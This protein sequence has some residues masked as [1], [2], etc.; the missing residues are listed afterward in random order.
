MTK[1]KVKVGSNTIALNKRARHEYFIEDEIEAG[2]DFFLGHCYPLFINRKLALIL[3]N[4]AVDSKKQKADL[5][6]P[7]F[8]K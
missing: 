4:L 6:Q 1:K 8:T 7:F 3:P 2:L 5:T